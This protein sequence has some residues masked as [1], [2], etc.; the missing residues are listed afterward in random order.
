M[1]KS[2][3]D[4]M[5]GVLDGKNNTPQTVAQNIQLLKVLASA[6][7]YTTELTVYVKDYHSRVPLGFYWIPFLTLLRIKV[8]NEY[9]KTARIVHDLYASAPKE[10]P[11]VTN[12]VINFDPTFGYETLE[13]PMEDYS[14][15]RLQPK[16][17]SDKSFADGR[18]NAS[19]RFLKIKNSMNFYD[20]V[21]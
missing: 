2:L 11:N 9:Q 6:S 4:A 12:F 1:E 17:A 15:F 20:G 13:G 21:V 10:C 18:Y 16:I 7:G 14:E 3:N 5:V 19:L 8:L